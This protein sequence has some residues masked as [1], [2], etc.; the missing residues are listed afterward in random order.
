VNNFEGFEHDFR[1]TSQP[2]LS[3]EPEQIEPL[4]GVRN[5][6]KNEYDDDEN[7]DGLPPGRQGNVL[8]KDRGMLQ[9]QEQDEQGPYEPADP[10]KDAHD[11]EDTQ[12]KLGQVHG[13]P[14]DQGK[15]DMPP[16]E[17]A[18]GK[19]VKG[20]T[21]IPTHPAKATGW[22]RMSEPGGIL[23]NNRPVIIFKRRGSPKTMDSSLG[24]AGTTLDRDRPM[25]R[26]GRA[27]MKPVSGPAAPMSN[28]CCFLVM[29]DLILMNAPNVPIR[30]GAGM[31]NGRVASIP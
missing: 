30:V 31:K 4:H 28:S 5:E 29:G 16:V 22:S 13:L 15:K 9:S 6:R 17:L 1:E 3:K 8:I 27:R 23:L 12:E 26:A 2:E 24:S 7:A 21:R 19:E 20:V 14:A 18:Q 10:E 11:H 25:N